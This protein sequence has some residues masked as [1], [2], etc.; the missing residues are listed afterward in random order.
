MIRNYFKIAFRNIW[1]SKGYASI[2]IVGLSVAFCI[3]VFLFLTAYFQLSFDNFHKDGDRIYQTYFFS[4]DPEKAEKGSSMPFPL[5]PALK[6][7]F[8]EVE[9]AARL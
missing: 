3:S 8:P 4:N 2:N 6:A 9:A 5:T 1:K 7:E